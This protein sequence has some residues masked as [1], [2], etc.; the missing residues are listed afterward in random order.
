MSKFWQIVLLGAYLA[1]KGWAW[2]R[3]L[4]YKIDHRCCSN[5]L[6]F[7]WGYLEDSCGSKIRKYTVKTP[8]FVIFPEFFV[9][10]HLLIPNGVKCFHPIG[11]LP[12]KI[13]LRTIWGSFRIGWNHL[14]SARE[15]PN[16]ASFSTKSPKSWNGD[17]VISDDDIEIPNI[18][19]YSSRATKQPVI[20][21]LWYRKFCESLARV[22]LSLHFSP[23]NQLK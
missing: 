23:A 16:E 22:P 11:F 7:S 5:G 21:Q 19:L 18:V 4:G 14:F 1:K 6:G 10:F 17:Y 15:A 3:W 8:N 9:L 13:Y 2:D 20:T 12:Y